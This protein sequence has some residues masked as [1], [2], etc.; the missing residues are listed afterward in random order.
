MKQIKDSADKIL[1]DLG[2]F[3]ELKNYGVPHMIGSYTMDVMSHN[4][5]DIV[6]SNE[7]MNIEKLYDITKYIINK[8]HPSWYEA[9]Q[10]KTDEGKTVWFHGFEATINNESWNFDIWFFDNDIIKNTENF[11]NRIKCQLDDDPTKRNTI[12]QIKKSLIE[13]NM[14]SFD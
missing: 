10:E 3:D 5:L 11:C 1:Y 14:Y 7:N 13:R 9:K 12:I 8:Y 2:L 4:D 6:V